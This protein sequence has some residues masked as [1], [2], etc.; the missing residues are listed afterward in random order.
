MVGEAGRRDFW[1]SHLDT[2]WASGR[3]QR[4]YC[5]EHGLCETQF[6]HW[7]GRLRTG[8]RRRRVETQLV[9]VSVIEH[10]TP[11]TERSEGKTSPQAD[12]RRADLSLVFGNGLRLEIGEGFDSGVLRRVLKVLGDVG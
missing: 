1:R 4:A 10:S 11:Q 3:T 2:W 12:N 8:S 5:Q 9:P 7:K 6:S